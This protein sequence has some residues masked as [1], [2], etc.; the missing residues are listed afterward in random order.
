MSSL[1][2]KQV[3]L[4]RPPGSA[5]QEARRK[6]RLVSSCAAP[7]RISVSAS[8]SGRGLGFQARLAEFVL[9]NRLKARNQRDES[10]EIMARAERIVF[11][12]CKSWFAEPDSDA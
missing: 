7:N 11:V 5:G 8:V 12:T 2:I 6:P 4:D 9:L 3:A 10:A 1:P